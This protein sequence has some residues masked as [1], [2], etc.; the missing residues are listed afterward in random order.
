M[1]AI[2]C[3]IAISYPVLAT[4]Q[5]STLPCV[6]SLHNKTASS[7]VFDVYWIM[8]MYRLL[9]CPRKDSSDCHIRHIHRPPSKMVSVFV[10]VCFFPPC[11]LG[12][13]KL[14]FALLPVA[15]ASLATES[16]VSVD[17]TENEWLCMFPQVV[18][19]VVV[20]RLP[21]R[22][23]HTTTSSTPHL[24]SSSLPSP[25]QWHS[26]QQLPCRKLQTSPRAA[27]DTG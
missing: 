7:C 19:V 5:Q 4:E 25:C 24:N 16:V 20:G 11:L 17:V 9:L 1:S 12:C 22:R 6:H 15:H 27:S 18:L 8:L 26:L 3:W 21:R 13:A 2:V 23:H 14:L 10:C